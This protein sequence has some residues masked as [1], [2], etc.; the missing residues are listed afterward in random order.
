MLEHAFMMGFSGSRSTS[1]ADSDASTSGVS[2]NDS[3]LSDIMV[4]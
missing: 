4:S 3:N 2:S 1:P